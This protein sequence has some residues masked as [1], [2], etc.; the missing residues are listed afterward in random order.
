MRDGLSL[1]V[2]FGGIGAGVRD[3]EGG[4]SRNLTYGSSTTVPVLTPFA[5]DRP[6]TKS[7]RE[8]SK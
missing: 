3:R 4:E 6:A 8:V 5:L 7:P 2:T 1:G